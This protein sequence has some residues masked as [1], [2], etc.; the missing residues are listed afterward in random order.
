MSSKHSTV[1]PSNRACSLWRSSFTACLAFVAPLLLAATAGAQSLEIGNSPNIIGSGARALGMGGAFIAVADD[2][3]AA[4]WNPGGLTQLERPEVS[5]VYGFERRRE[6]LNG[7]LAPWV[8]GRNETELDAVN[9]AS[10]VYP[11]PLPLLGGR[12]LVLSLNY[13]RRYDLKRS[14]DFRWYNNA[15][16]RPTPGLPG[17]SIVAGYTYHFR[18]EGTLSALT[19]AAAIEITKRLSVG[20][21]LNLYR[22]AFGEN[23]WEEKNSSLVSL[24][25]DISQT[26]RHAYLRE[27]EDFHGENYTLGLL[28]NATDRLS[29]GAVYHTRLKANALLTQTSWSLTQG[30]PRVQKTTSWRFDFPEA[31]GLGV[32]YRFP[33]DKLTLSADATLRCWSHFRSI[34]P[35][36]K[37]TSPV[38]GKETSQ[39]HIRDLYTV[40][41]GFEYVFVDKTKFVQNFMPSIR[42]GLFYDPEPAESDP[43]DVYGVA[44]GLGVLIKDR[45]NLD[46]AYQFRY[47][48]HARPD[49]FPSTRYGVSVADAKIRQ[50]QFLVSTVIYF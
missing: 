4:S 39:S 12:N 28:W 18:A 50:H 30:S 33:G 46:F 42:G 25:G 10:I 6:N 37:E 17:R 3:T 16:I 26:S 38:S 5:I 40:R 24:N 45:V 14:L 20:L 2:A 19:P 31:Y 32:A 36:G 35:K 15:L 23:R 1:R 48:N 21:A 44:V 47:G 27:Y 22:D 8:T 13:Q 29:V 49:T 7:G 43:V 34:G 11:V 41:A 9:Y